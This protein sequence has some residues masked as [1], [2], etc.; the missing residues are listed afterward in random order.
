MVA[1]EDGRFR[2]FPVSSLC[3]P[4]K[5]ERDPGS[6][7]ALCA[8]QSEGSSVA[9]ASRWHVLSLTPRANRSS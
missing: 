3:N 5:L 4:L 7:T 2:R 6:R 8:R 1:L 9:R